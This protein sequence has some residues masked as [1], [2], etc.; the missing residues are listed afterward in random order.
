MNSVE[1]ALN[2]AGGAT[3]ITTP[4]RGEPSKTPGAPDG[5]SRES[6]RVLANAQRIERI[7]I[8]DQEA[9]IEFLEAQLEE[10][11]QMRRLELNDLRSRRQAAERKYE[12]AEAGLP[13][14]AE[15]PIV[16]KKTVFTPT[17]AM[18]ARAQDGYLSK[19]DIDNLAL[20]AEY[21][22]TPGM[23][24]LNEKSGAEQGNDDT[25]NTTGGV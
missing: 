15:A 9:E 5:R 2:E 24:R 19:E 12:A 13:G 11:R 10:K 3:G 20:A 7:M 17:P 6:E 18:T 22:R 25:A 8:E 4:A 21:H 1:K 16:Q 23:H 14:A